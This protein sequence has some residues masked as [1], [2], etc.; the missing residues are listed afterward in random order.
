MCFEKEILTLNNMTGRI[1]VDHIAQVITITPKDVDI[2]LF[3]EKDIIIWMREFLNN[4]ET[5]S[6]LV[7]TPEE[8]I[9][10]YEDCPRENISPS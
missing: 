2:S 1:T 9:I 8:H 3:D 6:V 5:A 7:G 4:L 10:A